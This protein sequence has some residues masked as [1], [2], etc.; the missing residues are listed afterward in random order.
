MGLAR[1]QI[2][3]VGLDNRRWYIAE[4][5]VSYHSVW[6]HIVPQITKQVIA[7]NNLVT[8]QQLIE[9]AIDRVRDDENLQDE[10]AEQSIELIDFHRILAEILA[11][12]HSHRPAMRWSLVLKILVV[13]DLRLIGWTT[14]KLENGLS[15]ANLRD[16][17][18]SDGDDQT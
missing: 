12:D 6:N 10:L 17:L 2:A 9:I 3:M 18:L 13:H 14:W 1:S 15:L 11:A 7:A 8:K 16:D 5:E 4:A